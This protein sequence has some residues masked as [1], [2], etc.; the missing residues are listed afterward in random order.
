MEDFPEYNIF[1]IGAGFSRPAGLPLGLELF[2]EVIAEATYRGLYPENSF[3]K[4]DIL[5]FE[6][7]L[8]NTRSSKFDD[9]GI[10]GRAVLFLIVLMQ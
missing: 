6:E 8:K 9:I 1:I 5:K 3:L 7:Y 2:E 4:R 10:P